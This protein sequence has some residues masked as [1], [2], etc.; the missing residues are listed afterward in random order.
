[1]GAAWSYTGTSTTRDG[2]VTATKAVRE[3]TDDQG[4]ARALAD[5]LASF[6]P[7]EG[8]NIAVDGAWNEDGGMGRLN[9]TI[10]TQNLKRSGVDLVRMDD[11]VTASRGLTATPSDAVKPADSA[12]IGVL[13]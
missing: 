7:D 11:T 2:H 4:P 13:A 8:Q 9:I 12:P 5:A 1:M 3:L 6:K 10:T